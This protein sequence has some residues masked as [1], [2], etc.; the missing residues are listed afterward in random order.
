LRFSL[1]T[2]QSTG[3]HRQ[4]SKHVSPKQRLVF[5]SPGGA[6]SGAE[7]IRLARWCKRYF[8][9]YGGVEVS[10]DWDSPDVAKFEYLA[11]GPFGLRVERAPAI[12]RFYRDRSRVARDGD[13]R[14]TLIV[15]R[16]DSASERVTPSQSITLP[17]G[18]SILFDRSQASAHVCPGGSHRLVL[19]LPRRTACS[20]LPNVE[21]LVGTVIPPGNQ[22]MRL[23]AHYAEGLLGDET[24]SDPAILAHAAQNL[25]DLMVLAFDTDRDRTEVARQRGLRAVRLAAVLRIIR[26]D[27]ADPEISPEKVATRLGISARYLHALL[28]K[29]G[30]SFAERVHELRLARAFT[31]LCSGAGAH[32]KVSDAAYAAGFS[33]LSHFNRSFRRRYGLT[34]TAARGRGAPARRI[35]C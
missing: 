35:L 16:G 14:F 31:V 34:P 15:N 18:A 11:L 21:D 10:G 1:P 26:A 9:S 13:D 24:L 7:A 28:Q 4:L 19:I 17:A 32:R 5:S 22:P 33:D 25:L 12:N 3:C 23:L 2:I 8:E 27:Y 30:M 29:T 20:A 6:A